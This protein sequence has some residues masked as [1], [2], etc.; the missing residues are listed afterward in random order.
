MPNISNKKEPGSNNI[1]RASDHIGQEHSIPYSISVG[2]LQKLQHQYAT[3][4]SKAF[5]TVSAR[6]EIF[7][8]NW[9]KKA[10][11]EIKREHGTRYAG[12]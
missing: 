4:S 2:I 9:D 12:T 7:I 6:T 5:K 1:H 3:V 10:T 8:S 11:Y